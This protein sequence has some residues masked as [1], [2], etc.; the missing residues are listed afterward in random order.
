MVYAAQ[1]FAGLLDAINTATTGGA[2]SGRQTGR[3][4][5]ATTAK[6]T[7]EQFQRMLACEHGGMNESLAELYA[8]KGDEKYLKRPGASTTGGA[9]PAG[10]A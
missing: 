8:R 1:I 9:R 6:L 3:L 4:G 2:G 7:E 10:P 5:G